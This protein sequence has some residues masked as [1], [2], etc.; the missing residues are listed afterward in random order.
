MGSQKTSEARFLEVPQ[1]KYLSVL[2]ESLKNETGW[3]LGGRDA[4]F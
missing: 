3:G 4:L 1:S 2:R